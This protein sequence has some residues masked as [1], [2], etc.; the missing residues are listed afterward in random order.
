MDYATSFYFTATEIGLSL[1]GLALLL[2]A[3]HLAALFVGQAATSSGIPWWDAAVSYFRLR[4]TSRSGAED[5]HALA[6]AAGLPLHVADPADS[7]RVMWLVGMGAVWAAR[8]G[9]RI[10]L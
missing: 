9:R 1:A 2:V 6:Q 3:S 8:R 4:V 7:S 5:L 10:F